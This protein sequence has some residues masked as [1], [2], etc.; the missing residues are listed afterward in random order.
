M[1][2]WWVRQAKHGRRDFAHRACDERH[3]HERLPGPISLGIVSRSVW[4]LPRRSMRRTMTS[5]T[6]S[7]CR[8]T[9]GLLPWLALLS[10][11]IA[12]RPAA[13][14]NPEGGADAPLA[15]GDVLDDIGM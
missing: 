8:S 1:P 12:C 6:T 13:R 4:Q 5:A 15:S 9:A 2:S 11:A 3:S 14:E 7:S 10:A